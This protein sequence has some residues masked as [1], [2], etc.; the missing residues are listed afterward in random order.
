MDILILVCER[1]CYM[2][3]IE[4]REIDYSECG[5]LNCTRFTFDEVH[6]SPSNK[7]QST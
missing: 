6:P 7:E 2:H 4:D 3:Y 5:I 1:N